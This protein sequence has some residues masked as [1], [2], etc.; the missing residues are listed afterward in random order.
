M[1]QS[2]LLSLLA[3]LL[4]QS[5]V[6][7]GPIDLA[8]VDA[9]GKGTPGSQG[10]P[11]LDIVG[12]PAI[13]Q[14]LFDARISNGLPAGAQLLVSST[15]DPTA[16]PAFGARL[17]PGLRSLR[18]PTTLDETGS[19]A[20]FAAS[21]RTPPDLEGLKLVLQGLVVDAAATGGIA[22]TNGLSLT[23]GLGSQAASLFPDS[24]LF[25][26]PNDALE[27]GS[28]TLGDLDGNGE[29]EIVVTRSGGRVVV[30]YGFPDGTHVPGGEYD[31]G[32]GDAFDLHL[33]DLD[34]DSLLAACG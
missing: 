22:F 1:I 19:S 2:V 23:V 25:V 32:I 31:S 33:A 18:F 3:G 15:L 30:G 27:H 13:G 6:L 9:V 24:Q 29:P 26:D 28:I 10:G 16:L 12:L 5:A 8:A 14:P 20:G 4:L 11:V 7:A 21:G 34:G 17:W